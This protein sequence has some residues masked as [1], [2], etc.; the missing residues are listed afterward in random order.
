MAMANVTI[1]GITFYNGSGYENPYYLT[2]HSLYSVPE[3]QFYD[4]LQ[5]EGTTV[6][7]YWTGQEYRCFFRRNKDTNQTNDNVSLFYPVGN[8][9]RPGSIITHYGKAYLILNQESLENRVYHR[10]DGLN[11]D[12]LLTT[13]DETSTNEISV[14]C[15]AY[16]LTG[17]VPDKSDIMSVIGGNVELMTGDNEES[18]KL[19]VNQE[20]NAMGSWHSI[21][22]VNFKSGICR[23]EASIIQG[24]SHNPVFALKVDAEGTYLQGSTVKLRAE[25]TIDEK[26]VGNPTIIW[27]SLNPEIAEVTDDGTVS[28]IETG[29]CGIKCYW[30]EHNVT[31]TVYFEVIAEPTAPEYICEISGSDTIRSGKSSVYTAIFYQNDGVTEDSSITPLWSLEVPNEIKNMV[32]M[33]KQIGNTVTIS[34][35]NGSAALGHSFGLNLTDSTGQYHSIKTIKITSLF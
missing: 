15:F 14:P 22:S 27:S 20:F 35:S 1:N 17:T 34:I 19:K 4:Y 29:T 32:T 26:P 24:S 6:K 11:A 25:P 9:I 33:S 21:V 8:G 18:R 5:R 3:A 12:V 16:D 23:I 7:N 31:T 30:K 2:D 10:S 28:F 13:Y